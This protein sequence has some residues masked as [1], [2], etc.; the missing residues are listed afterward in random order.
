MAW[1]TPLAMPA[2]PDGSMAVKNSESDFAPG[3]VKLSKRTRVGP[4]C[5]R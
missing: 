5:N 4:A 1:V 3:I 2:Q